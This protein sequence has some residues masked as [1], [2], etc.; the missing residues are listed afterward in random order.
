MGKKRS[1]IGALEETPGVFLWSH[2]MVKKNARPPVF[3]HSPSGP[4]NLVG[5]RPLPLTYNRTCPEQVGQSIEGERSYHFE[6]EDRGKGDESNTDPNTQTHTNK[7]RDGGS[8]QVCF[9]ESG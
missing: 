6:T 3:T 1:N 4:F 7:P 8:G 9:C 5:T 2:F